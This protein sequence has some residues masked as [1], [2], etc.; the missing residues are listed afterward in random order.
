MVA[1]LGTRVMVAKR[2][3]FGTRLRL[4][5]PPA[6]IGAIPVEAINAGGRVLM[7][8]EEVQAVPA[9]WLS[10]ASSEAMEYNESNEGFSQL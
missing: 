9:Y 1:G 5:A 6:A 4:S 3:G 7:V 8:S 10:A 2:T